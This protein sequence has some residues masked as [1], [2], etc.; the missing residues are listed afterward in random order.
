MPPAK[1]DASGYAAIHRSLL[2][3]LL[4]RVAQRGESS[5]YTAAGGGK[6]QLWPGSGVFGSKPKWIVESIGWMEFVFSVAV[7]AL[8]ALGWR[9]RVTRSP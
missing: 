5:E 2:S 6:F 9:M 4:S 1:D 7:V 3:G 8:V